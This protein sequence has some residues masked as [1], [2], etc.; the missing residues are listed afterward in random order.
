MGT[1]MIEDLF[2]GYNSCIL[3]YG[4]TGSGKTYSMFGENGIVLESLEQI[5]KI[6]KNYNYNVDIGAV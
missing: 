1:E 6:N 3:C 4:Q 5:L 2:N